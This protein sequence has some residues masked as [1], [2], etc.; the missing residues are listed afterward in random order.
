M[1]YGFD[2]S[3]FCE[4]SSTQNYL[5]C[6]YQIFSKNMNICGNLVVKNYKN[7]LESSQIFKKKKIDL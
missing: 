5:S 4:I 2:L 3:H 6:N 7:I 1:L